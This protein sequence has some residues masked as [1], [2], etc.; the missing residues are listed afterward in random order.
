MEVHLTDPGAGPLPAGPGR[1]P[2]ETPLEG[3]DSAGSSIV[4]QANHALARGQTVRALALARQAVAANPDDADA[5]L[6][7][8]AACQAGG[9]VAGARDAYRTCLLRAHTAN[10]SE[11]RLLARP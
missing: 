11:C 9:D 5:W 7:L 6:T 4:T 8:G 2:G 3:H 1:S 10:I